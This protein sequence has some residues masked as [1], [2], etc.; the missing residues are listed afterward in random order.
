VA[1]RGPGSIGHRPGEQR[2]SRRLTV[3]AAAIAVACLSVPGCASP[4]TPATPPPSS[5]PVPPE[6]AAASCDDGIKQ[7]FHPDPQTTVLLVQAFT[8]GSPIALA[9]TPADPAPAAAPADVCLVKLLVGPGNPGDPAAPSTSPGIGI[10]V[11]LPT[12][13]NWNG[14]IRSY[15]SGGWAGGFQADP[16]GIGGTGSIDPMHLAAVGKGYVVSTSD[17]GHGGSNDSG[18]NGSFTISPDGTINTVGWQDFSERSMHE[19]AVKTKALVKEFY[20]AQQRYAYWDGF[21]TG[22]RQGYKIAQT[23]PDDYDGIL[24]GAPAINWSRFITAE[25]YPQIVMLRDLGAAIPEPKL[26]AANAAAS[27]ACGGSDLGF[28]LDPLQCRYDPATD[29]AALCTGVAGNAGVIGTSA[30]AGTCLSA[31]EAAAI[32]KIWYGQ[33]V[34]GDAPDPRVDNGSDPT[35]PATHL[36]YGMPRG[37]STAVLAGPTAFPIAA[38]MVAIELEEPALGQPGFVTA[39]GAGTD[40]WRSLNY[41]DLAR[42]HQ[43]GLDLQAKFSEINTDEP[44]LSGARDSGVKVLSYH[45][46]ADEFIFAQGSINYFTRAA[47][48]VGGTEKLTEFNRLFMIPGLA[49]DPTFSSAASIDP[50]TRDVTSVAKVPLP[51]PSTGRDEL[52]TALRNW[53]EQGQAPNRIDLSSADGSVTMPV[54]SYPEKATHNGAGSV[55]DGASYACK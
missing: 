13:T 19:L 31:A 38:D 46:L 40:G 32:N 36:W 16:T 20:G 35:L 18:G 7:R 24:A 27:A 49:H 22:G 53:V 15:G 8:A 37:T 30:D 52:F 4:S 54:C 1:V 14:I 55:T 41:S 23:F 48:A 28:L 44:D 25:L 6:P 2:A 3:A 43:R 34:R 45:G 10:E 51:Q 39:A 29:A 9:N 5:S 33:T 47:A 11:W 42:A 21:S 26:N 50:A 12:P 17:H